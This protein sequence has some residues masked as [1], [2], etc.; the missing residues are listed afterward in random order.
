MT[1]HWPSVMAVGNGSHK[2][3]NGI[4]GEDEHMCGHI[5]TKPGARPDRLCA[6]DESSCDEPMTHLLSA[7]G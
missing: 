6:G 1:S 4:A 3:T 7:V 5:Q 2:V